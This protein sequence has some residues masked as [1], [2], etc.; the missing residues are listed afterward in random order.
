MVFRSAATSFLAPSNNY[1]QMRSNAGGGRDTIGGL[2]APANGYRGNLERRGIQPR[3]HARENRQ[4]LKD[5][6]QR[7]RINKMNEVAQPNKDFKLRRFDGVQSKVAQQM[8]HDTRDDESVMT[9]HDFVRRGDREKKAQAHKAQVEAK[10]KQWRPGQLPGD[11]YQPQ[12]AN[13]GYRER[14]AAAKPRVPKATEE[15]PQLAPRKNIDYLRNNSLAAKAPAKKSPSKEN[16]PPAQPMHQRGQVPAYL[17]QRKQDLK[18]AADARIR[19]DTGAPPGMIL[20]PE[21]ERQE[22]LRTLR[23][24]KTEGDRQLGAMP[25]QLRTQKQIQ[26]YEE[27]ERKVKEIEGAIKLFSK[28]KVF[29]KD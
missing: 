3:N 28:P 6:Q 8:V 12:N 2:I 9:G 15:A 23:E 22:T 24:S 13:G 7:N 29:I 18:A 19:V 16:N 26:R 20:M 4:A 25:L 10:T 5:A 1:A 21:A 27:L 11:D 17:K 14:A